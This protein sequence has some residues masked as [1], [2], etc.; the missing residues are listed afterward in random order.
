MSGQIQEFFD[1]PHLLPPLLTPSAF[2]FILGTDT[3]SQETFT[4]IPTTRENSPY[5]MLRTILALAGPTMLEQLL[6]TAVSYV[7]IAMIGVLGTYATA[8]VGATT[9]VHWL[10]NSSISALGIGFLAHIARACGEEAAQTSGKAAR[11]TGQALLVA[12]FTGLFFTALTLSLSPLIPLWMQVD[13]ALSELTSRYFFILYLPMLPRTASLILGTSLRAAGDT[14]T[15][16]KIS[17]LMNLVNVVLNYFLIFPSHTVFVGG[18][19]LSLPGAGLGV[20]GA[21]IAIEKGFQH[22]GD[23]LR[24]EG[25]RIESLAVIES[26]EDGKVY[27]RNA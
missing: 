6:Q 20:T 1:L 3:L 8:A 25:V 22:G 18:M 11:I 12:F 9:T 26:M 24:N 21:A 27:F 2:N 5:R 13:P 7:D 10:I 4:M 14:K 15:P 16:M 17:L 23:A 19:T